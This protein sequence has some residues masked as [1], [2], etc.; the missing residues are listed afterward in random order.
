MEYPVFHCQ[1][2]QRII[3]AFY[4]MVHQTVID[5]RNRPVPFGL[6]RSRHNDHTS[7]TPLEDDME[8]P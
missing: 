7:T 6:M 4:K 2:S 3:S 5:Y 1:N 8:G